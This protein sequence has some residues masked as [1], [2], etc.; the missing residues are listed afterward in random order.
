MATKLVVLSIF[1]FLEI[2]FSQILQ[3]PNSGLKCHNCTTVLL[4][5]YHSSET[6]P[7]KAQ[8]IF[9][10]HRSTSRAQVSFQ[11]TKTSPQKTAF[12]PSNNTC[13]CNE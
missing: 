6:S 9:S 2:I 11:T 4:F 1:I 10:G 12:L 8:I 7:L 5:K 3:E 13:H